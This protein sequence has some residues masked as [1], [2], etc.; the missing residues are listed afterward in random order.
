[1]SILSEAANIV[2]GDRMQTYGTPRENHSR[3]AALWSAY[4]GF[5]ITPR[6][7]CMMNV[8]QKASRDRFKPHRDNLIDI[9][10]YAENA[11][12]CEPCDPAAD[13]LK[14]LIPSAHDAMAKFYK[15]KDC[16][17]V[18]DRRNDTS[19]PCVREAGHEGPHD[20]GHEWHA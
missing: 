8:L 10:G 16:P 18:L 3:T 1:M 14:P 9:A 6:D 20:S 11:Q 13:Y 12:R 15:K 4:F 7:V 17:F 5:N 2:D 19:L